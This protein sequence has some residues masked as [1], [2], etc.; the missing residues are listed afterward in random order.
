MM[1]TREAGFTLVE[2]LVALA[3]LVLSLSVFYR[4]L[5]E[6]ARGGFAVQA[7]EEAL[8]H[9]VN[10]LERL[11]VDLP[12]VSGTGNYPGGPHWQLKVTP[13]DREAV[14]KV[15]AYWVE[16]N[17]TDAGGAVLLRL[18]TAAIGPASP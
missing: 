11:G 4:A 7:R 18:D 17:V 2:A 16:L 13:L 9:A 15:I 10:H 12:I 14:S 6:G 8:T 3:I 5:G 1:Q